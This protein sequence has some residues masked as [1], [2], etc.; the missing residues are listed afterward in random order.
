VGV[1]YDDALILF[2]FGIDRADSKGGESG[3]L[4]HSIG[5]SLP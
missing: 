2:Q 1:A 3:P 5:D 4:T